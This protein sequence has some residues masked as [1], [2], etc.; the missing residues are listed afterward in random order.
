MIKTIGISR[1]SVDVQA[2]DIW[3]DGLSATILTWG[4]VVQDLRLAGHRPPLVLGFKKFKHYPRYSPHFGAIAGRYANRIA[5][6]QFT[7]DGT[8]HQLD[9]NFLGKHCL[10]GGKSGFGVRDWTIIDHAH[11]FV[12]LGL[13]DFDGMMGFPGECAITCRYEMKPGNIL[14]LT[15][16]ATTDKTTIFNPAHHSYFCLDDSND[17]RDHRLTI[18]ADAYVPVDSEAIPTGGT[19]PVVDSMFDFRSDRVIGTGPYD[20]NYCTGNE[21]GACRPVATVRSPKSGVKMTLSTTEPGL[22]FY[23]G[24]KLGP[25]VSGLIKPLYT[26]YSGLCLEPQIWP[27]APNNPDFPQA[28]LRPG[29]TY[30][31][32]TEFAFTMEQANNADQ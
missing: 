9:T 2:I 15:I 17:I 32:Q 28:I 24:H 10:H 19:Q 20:H 6:G 3:Q 31:Q 8:P 5:N 16:T 25:P 7:L 12:E 29:E 22:Q 27:D 11:D 13:T 14:A 30:R 18:H 4:A 1:D 21:R 23:S 26:A